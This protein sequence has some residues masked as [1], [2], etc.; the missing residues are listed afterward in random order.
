MD[1]FLQPKKEEKESKL[2]E[3]VHSWVILGYSPI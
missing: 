1:A 2:F 3:T